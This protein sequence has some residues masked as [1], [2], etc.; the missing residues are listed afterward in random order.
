M[1]Y[2]KVNQK[3]FNPFFMV[4]IGILVLQ[5]AITIFIYSQNASL[6]FKIAVAQEEVGLIEAD[7]IELEKDLY[8]LLDLTNADALVSEFGL[9]KDV[10]P[11]Y[12]VSL[13]N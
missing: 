11:D 8:N 10:S 9:V 5:V 7:T 3:I 2:L 13:G 1:T 12:I 6:R 4:V